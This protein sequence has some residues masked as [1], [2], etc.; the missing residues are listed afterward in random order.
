MCGTE[1]RAL[2]SGLADL[3]L[4]TK[5]VVGIVTLTPSLRET[6]TRVSHRPASVLLPSQHPLVKACT[7]SVGAVV[8]IKQHPELTQ[9]GLLSCLC[10]VA[11][12]KS[13]ALL[14][15]QIPPCEMGLLEI[16]ASTGY[17]VIG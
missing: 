2:S 1:A 5:R 11:S 17:R 4:R 16:S 14:E 9:I 12:S 3:R 7:A 6:S 8:R 15:P 13:L 10:W